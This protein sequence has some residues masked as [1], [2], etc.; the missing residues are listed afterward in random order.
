MGTAYCAG[1]AITRGHKRPRCE[2]LTVYAGT[3]RS[4]MFAC[5]QASLPLKTDPS[6]LSATNEPDALERPGLG[7]GSG[8]WNTVAVGISVF[9]SESPGRP[10]AYSQSLSHRQI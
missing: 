9:I 2:Q 8:L 10:A 7:W 5:C 4:G 1:G 6:G 3:Q